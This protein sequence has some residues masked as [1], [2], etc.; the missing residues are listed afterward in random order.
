MASA[1]VSPPAFPATREPEKLR[2]EAIL[3][4]RPDDVGDLAGDKRDNLYGRSRDHVQVQSGDRSADQNISSCF[5]GLEDPV[6][7]G[8]SG[9]KAA[10]HLQIDRSELGFR[11]HE[12]GAGLEDR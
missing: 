4:V 7:L 10:V 9:Q 2:A 5:Y 6:Q 12:L 8:F 1:P 11:C 3:A